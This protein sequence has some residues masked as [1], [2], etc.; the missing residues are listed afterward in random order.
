MAK[1]TLTRELSGEATS[2]KRTSV[3]P[4]NLFRNADIADG[5]VWV[6]DGDYRVVSIEEVHTTA[7]TDGGAVTLMPVKAS[8]TTK[9]PSG[10]ALLTGTF[11]MKAAANTVQTGTLVSDDAALTLAAGDRL[12]FNFT[13]TFT[14]LAGVCVTFVLLPLRTQA[15]GVTQTQ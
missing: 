2:Y 14:S 10:T 6:S 5:P 12:G 4:I 9:T 7:G 1:T 15:Y 8:G 3:V 11:N 13:G